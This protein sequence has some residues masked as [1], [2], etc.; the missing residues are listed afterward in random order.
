MIS[1]FKEFTKNISLAYKYLIK[2]K[3]HGIK[4]FGLK[5]SNVMCLFYIGESETGLTATELCKLCCEDKA[6]I[7]KA[8]SALHESGYV[9]LENEDAKK[10]RSTYFLTES[11]INVVDTLKAKIVSAVAGGGEG[12]SDSDREVFYKS[13]NTIVENLEKV[14]KM[15]GED[16]NEEQ[17]KI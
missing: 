1:R 10:Y 8:L 14:A 3:S 7:S 5:G 13:L 11:G 2:I 15:F 4:E 17:F 16:K 9:R 6:A 12:L